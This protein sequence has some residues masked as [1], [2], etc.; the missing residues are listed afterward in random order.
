M[1][2]ANAYTWNTEYSNGTGNQN[3]QDPRATMNMYICNSFFDYQDLDDRI[4][5]WKDEAIDN[6]K[7]RLDTYY[8]RGRLYNQT[9]WHID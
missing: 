3:F 2:A 4:N 9:S 5:Q 1:G 8:N 7:Y 6:I